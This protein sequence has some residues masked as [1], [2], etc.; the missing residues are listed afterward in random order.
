L[1]TRPNQVPIA[2]PTSPPFALGRLEVVRKQRAASR[3][4][5]PGAGWT[6]AVYM[7]LD[8]ALV[9]AGTSLTYCVRYLHFSPLDLKGT[10]SWNHPY[11]PQYAGLVFMYAAL[12]LLFCRNGDLYWTRGGLT[13]LEE[14]L[15]VGKAVILATVLLMV[16][17][18]LSGLKTISRAVVLGSACLNLTTLAAWR[19][20]KRHI[21]ELDISSGRRARNVLI[22]GAAEAGQQLAKVLEQNPDLG[23]IVCGFL[24]Q[25]NAAD[26]R[27]LGRV[28]AVEQVA[29]ANFVDEIFIT[30]PHDPKLVQEV[31]IKARDNRWDVKLV[32]DLYGGLSWGAPVGYLG[33]YPILELHRE[34]IPQLELFAKRIIDIFGS[35]LALVFISPLLLVLAILIKLDSPG[36]VLYSAPR[37]GKKGRKFRCYKFRSMVP[38]ADKIKD[39]LRSQNE[40]TGALFKMT[41]DPRVTRVG[42]WMRRYSLDELPQFWNVLKGDMSLV[43]PRPP[44]VDD[45]EQYRVDDLRRLDVTPGLTGLWQVTARRDP[46]FER[47]LE[48]DREYIENWTPWMDIKIILKTLPVVLAGEGQ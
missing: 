19:L 27:V 40:R 4:V 38:D 17:V 37:M 1:V 41:N 46:S 44:S 8:L 14:S 22:V 36:P 16:F 15:A 12:T 30:S 48:L 7:L 5:P 13:K 42:K 26:P 34:P 18:Y 6:H 33:E 31:A 32:P 11:Q 43:G 45:Y 35:S 28:E 25:E 24:D 20:W 29:R 9:M 23:Y 21:V 2:S 3:R 47:I 10:L 39:T